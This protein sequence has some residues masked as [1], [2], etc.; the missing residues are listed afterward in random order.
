[1]F[2]R[3]PSIPWPLSGI[4]AITAFVSPFTSDGMFEHP[5]MDLLR[6][7]ERMPWQAWIDEF[8]LTLRFLTLEQTEH[9]LKI[10]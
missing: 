6:V 10:L 3:R 4:H 7:V 5:R 1:M 9:R 8:E 2:A